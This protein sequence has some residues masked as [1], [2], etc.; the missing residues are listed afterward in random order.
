MVWIVLSPKEREKNKK[1]KYLVGRT[2]DCLLTTQNINIFTIT[3]QTTKHFSKHFV[4]IL[5]DRY[6]NHYKVC[7]TLAISKHFSKQFTHTLKSKFSKV[8]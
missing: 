5:E 7:L 1:D 3:F 8:S 4:Y 6:K 2:L